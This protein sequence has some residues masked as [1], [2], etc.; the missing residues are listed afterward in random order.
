MPN[1]G[2][3]SDLSGNFLVPA[4]SQRMT[5]LSMVT[6]NTEYSH[7]LLSDVKILQIRA[8]GDSNIKMAFVSG[9]SGTKYFTMPKNSSYELKDIKFSSSTLY[10]QADKA[11]EVLEI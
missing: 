5:N 10:V 7:A 1:I 3:T 8:R 4:T 9:E 6:A 2:S 11:N